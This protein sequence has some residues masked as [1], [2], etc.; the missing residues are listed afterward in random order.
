MAQSGDNSQKKIGALL[1]ALFSILVLVLGILQIRNTIYAP[2]ALKNTIPTGI[3][4]QIVDDNIDYQRQL[5]T[6][7][8]GLTDF[9]ELHVYGTSPYLYDTFGYGLSDAEVIKKGLPLCP[10]AG[11]N[12]SGGTTSATA[13]INNASSSLI[14][15][16][17]P[18]PENP[19]TTPQNL[20]LQAILHNP[21]QLRQIL[22]QSGQMTKADLDK[23]SD[24]DLLRTAQ[25]SFGSSTLPI[26]TSTGR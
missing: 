19:S 7:H 25:A 11:K 8:D 9:D 10:G 22:L 3:K 24:A 21:T 4:Q 15:S 1:L 14:S 20:D 12:C 5:D 26:S 18:S 23:I 13:G 2:F 16:F 17:N 6:D